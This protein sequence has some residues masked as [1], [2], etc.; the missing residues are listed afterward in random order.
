[1]PETL[2]ELNLLLVMVAKPR[3]VHRDGI[4]LQELRYFDPTLA[5]Y[6]GEVRVSYQTRSI[7]EPCAG[8]VK[9]RSFPVRSLCVQ[10]LRAP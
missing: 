1:M 5:A 10:R 6:V 2:S 4:H 8:T 9:D 7:T 3:T